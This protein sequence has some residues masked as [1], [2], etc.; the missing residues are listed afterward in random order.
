MSLIQRDIAVLTEGMVT[1]HLTE[2]QLEEIVLLIEDEPVDEQILDACAAALTHAL[3][4]RNRKLNR[5]EISCS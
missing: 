4:V 3:K 5:E 2:E 1:V